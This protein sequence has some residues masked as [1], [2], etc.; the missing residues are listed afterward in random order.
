MLTSI[1]AFIVVFTVLALAH[2]T[3]HLIWAKRAG[4]RV[5]EFGLGFGPRLFSFQKNGTTYSL[6][7]IPILAFVR[8]AGEGESEEDKNCPESESYLTKTPL[9]KFKT[10]VAG[11]M[12]NLLAALVILVFMSLAV[13][14]PAGLSN[15]IASISKGQA[16]E[17][18][19]L[20]VGDRLLAING[21]GFDKMEAAIEFIH[22][23]PDKPLRLVVERHGKKIKISAT[24]KFNEKLKVA[25]LGFSPKV[26]YSRTNP[27]R[28][29]YY[30]LEQ[31]ASMVIV[32]LVIVGRLIT[33]GV[34]LTDLAG[35]VGIAQITG[36]YA[37]TGLISLLYFAA[38]LNVNV[39]V[40]NLLPLPALDGGRIAFVIIEWIR[41]KPV[42]P[43]LEN[44]INYW[45]F[46]AL[47]GLMALVSANDILRIFRGQ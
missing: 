28:S 20:M 41:K 8:I 7:L 6:N 35:P 40:L 45:G 9:Q 4:I 43:K 17:K 19:G 26:N 16:A 24:P 47:L 30:G 46:V 25:L 44:K 5:F 2:E 12:M 39:G 38:F 32:T 42:D 15:E 3:G 36:K 23:N 18:A 27:L 29:I 14:V 33:G 1:V 37:Q 21:K 10:L 31:T 34:S 11:P 13:G 22:K